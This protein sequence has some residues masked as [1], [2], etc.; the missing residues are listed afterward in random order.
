MRTIKERIISTNKQV[1]I[2]LPKTLAKL[3]RSK[4]VKNRILTN[5]KIHSKILRIQTNF[6]KVTENK[7]KGISQEPLKS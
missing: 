6:K 2:K 7:I 1:K 5:R 3:N 4:K